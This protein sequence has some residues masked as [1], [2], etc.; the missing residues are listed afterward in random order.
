MLYHVRQKKINPT[1]YLQFLAHEAG[2]VYTNCLVTFWRIWRKKGVWLSKTSMQKLIRNTKLHSQTVQGIID[3][4]YDAV[5]SWREAKKTNPNARMPKRRKWYFVIPYKA[6][7]I[8][9]KDGQLILSNGKGN[10]PTVL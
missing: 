7:A 1:E 8:R 6:S 4:F 10:A 9:L 3:K 5:A 2:L